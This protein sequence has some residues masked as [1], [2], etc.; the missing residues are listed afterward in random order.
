MADVQGRIL[1]NAGMVFN[2]HNTDFSGGA[3]TNGAAD[4]QPAIQAAINAASAAGGGTVLLGPHTYWISD[5]L[6]LPSNVRVQGWSV[7]VSVVTSLDNSAVDHLG[8]KPVFRAAGTSSAKV[9]SVGLADLTV[10]NGTASTGSYTASKNGLEADYVDGLTVERVKFTEIQGTDGVWIWRSSN[11]R[12]RACLFYRWTYS[13]MTIYPDCQ[14][15]WVENTTF[16]TAVTT[17]LTNSYTLGAGSSSTY[18]GTSFV[19][20]LWVQRCTFLNN[21][22]WEGLDVHG[23]ENVWIRDN[24]IDNVRIGINAGLDTSNVPSGVLKNVVIEGNVMR[25]GT[26]SESADHYGIIVHGNADDTARAEHVTVRDN[27]IYGFG[28]ST[29]DTIGV[30]SAYAVRGLEISNNLV[31]NFAQAGVLLW[32]SLSD[33]RIHGNRFRNMRAYG[34][35]GA[36]CAI[37]SAL[38]WGVFNVDVRD[39]SLDADSWDQAPTYF[40]YANTAIGNVQVG[41]NRVAQVRTAYYGN[42]GNLPVER[43]TVPTTNLRLKYGDVVLTNTGKPGWYVSAVAGGE[44]GYGSVDTTTV[45]GTVSATSGS[46]TVTLGTADWR[47]LPEGMN[48]TIA[49]AGASGAAL[50]ARVLKNN[51]T[52]VILDTAASTT[53]TGTNLTMQGVT[54]VTP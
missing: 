10:R 43:S 47:W 12:V 1:D 15:V 40:L 41:H 9:T 54:L 32:Y 33:V 46:T 13:G 21:P 52:T 38:S 22:R 53:V 29:T 24:Y 25:Q 39:N 45:V 6:T 18:T 14:N 48:V 30:I 31:E 23:G 34:S 44:V 8:S 26:G 42:T 7:D 5:T 3:P 49:G 28:G 17:T 37:S 19:K 50:N 51:K 16:D 35:L 27:A 11:I 2:V 20:N 4:A 36:T